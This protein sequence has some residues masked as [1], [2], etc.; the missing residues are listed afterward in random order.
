MVPPDFMAWRVQILTS[1]DWRVESPVR[2]NHPTAVS[3]GQWTAGESGGELPV[4]S[5][6]IE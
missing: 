6:D 4:N 2:R 5:V 3:S 1:R